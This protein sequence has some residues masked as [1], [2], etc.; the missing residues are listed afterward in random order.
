MMISIIF[1]RP[2]SSFV[3]LSSARWLAFAG[4]RVCCNQKHLELSNTSYRFIY[5]PNHLLRVLAYRRAVCLSRERVLQ[6]FYQ[7]VF[8]V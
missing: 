4:W 6:P 2:V 5:L 1:C 7:D 3:A 8:G